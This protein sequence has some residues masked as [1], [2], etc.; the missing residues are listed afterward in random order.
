[1]HVKKTFNFDIYRYL[2]IF[3][4]RKKKEDIPKILVK[5]FLR[6]HKILA[7]IFIRKELERFIIEFAWE[8][9]KD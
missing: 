1:M 9:V 5:V 6:N 8:I 3:F 4:L 7:R 2:G